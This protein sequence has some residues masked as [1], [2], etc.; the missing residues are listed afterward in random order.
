MYN[1]TIV[2]VIKFMD[3]KVLYV[4]DFFTIKIFWLAW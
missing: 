1:R 2:L 4:A 3:A